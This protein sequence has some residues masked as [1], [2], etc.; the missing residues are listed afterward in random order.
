M[1]PDNGTESLTGE[2]G[3][4]TACHKFLWSVF[5]QEL[6]SEPVMMLMYRKYFF[7]L[8]EFESEAE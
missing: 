8:L 1:V 4:M 5:V 2:A 7:M 3:T 6:M